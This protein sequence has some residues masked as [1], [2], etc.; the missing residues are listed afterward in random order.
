MIILFGS[1]HDLHKFSLI[2]IDDLALLIN[3]IIGSQFNSTTN[4]DIYLLDLSDPNGYRWVNKYIVASPPNPSTPSPSNTAQ[5][6]L[7][8][9]SPSSP[10]SVNTLAIAL[11]CAFGVI[12]IGA[13]IFFY[14][15]RKKQN[16][17]TQG[18]LP[19]QPVN[20]E[21]KDLAYRPDSN[22]TLYGN[23]TFV[24]NMTG[25]QTPS[26]HGNQSFVQNQSAWQIPSAPQ[27]PTSYGGQSFV[28]NPSAWQTASTS[29]QTSQI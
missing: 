14:Y 9:N 2:Y 22:A 1:Y 6:T 10:S 13:L 8:A 24:Q 27:T 7:T 16:A 5:P 28:Q 17:R 11:P 29:S 21:V 19:P 23:Q 12:V 3:L 15:K 18:G 4:S 25:W 20:L 26:S